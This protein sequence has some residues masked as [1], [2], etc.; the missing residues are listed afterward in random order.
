LEGILLSDLGIERPHLA[1][2]AAG[3]SLAETR[4][5]LG[6]DGL[7]TSQAALSEFLSWFSLRQQLSRNEQTVESVLDQLKRTRP[8]LTEEDLFAAG[9]SFFSALA[10]EQ[11]DTKGWKRTQDLRM[12]RELVRLERQKFQRDTCELFLRWYA[13]EQA[14]QIASGV[15]TNSEKIERLGQLM[16]GDGWK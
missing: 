5:W 12:K 14:K 10:I 1:D 8:D 16:F 3:H 9:Q 13:D 15:Q 11:R 6:E 7:R 2:Y 4:V